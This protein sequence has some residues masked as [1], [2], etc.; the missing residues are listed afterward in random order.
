M[1]DFSDDFFLWL[2]AVE[3]IG[4][5][6][7][8]RLYEKLRFQCGNLTYQPDEDRIVRVSSCD[9]RRSWKNRH[10]KRELED[11]R[12]ELEELNVGVVSW[13]DRR[14]PA[15]LKEIPDFPAYLFFRGSWHGKRTHKHLEKCV[16]VVGT[17]KMS[18]Y[19][20]NCVSEIVPVIAGNGVSIVSG[21]AMGVDAQV[22]SVMLTKEHDV[23]P[24]A[25][26][27]GGPPGGY[28]ASS[29]KVYEDIVQRG[30]VLWE[31]PPGTLVNRQMFAVRNRII[32]GLVSGVL[33]IESAS[34]GGSLITAQLAL[35][36]GREAGAVPGNIFSP[37]SEGCH[38]LINEGAQPVCSGGDML[39]LVYGVGAD[40]QNA[41]M[42]ERLSAILKNDL[43]IY[44]FFITKTAGDILEKGVEIETLLHYSS[45]NVTAM[46]V[47][48]THLEVEGILRLCSNS[49][50]K[51]GEKIS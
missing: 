34:R 6:T 37:T 12:G 19:G 25:V 51:I 40:C 23:I 48:L 21:L 10:W 18:E 14:Y 22:H 43:K 31:F 20:R 49:V 33:V 24:I 38:R 11:F 29:R 46:R 30:L 17:R 35:E 47:V 4:P 7:L 27:P 16:A 44:P 5:R 26:L 45:L 3:H 36:Y 1:D 42:T 39:S 50:I 8:V 28:P 15:R 13:T 32:A 9:L 2:Y 41:L